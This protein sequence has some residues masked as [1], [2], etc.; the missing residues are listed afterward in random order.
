[1]ARQY[2]TLQEVPPPLKTELFQVRFIRT[3]YNYF[4]EIQMIIVS[5]NECHPEKI[6]VP[7]RLKGEEGVHHASAFYIPQHRILAALHLMV[8]DVTKKPTQR[9]QI[10][11]LKRKV[12]MIEAENKKLRKALESQKHIK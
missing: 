8:P 9:A 12:E 6:L 11:H 7:K 1:V 4:N 2:K 3:N 10:E 5:W